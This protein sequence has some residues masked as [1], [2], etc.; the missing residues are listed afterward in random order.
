MTTY[1]KSV[2]AAGL[3]VFLLSGCSSGS[4]ATGLGLSIGGTWKGTLTGAKGFKGT[5]TLQLA[6]SAAGAEDPFAAATLTGVI[7]T[8]K[9]CIGSGS[10]AEGTLSGNDVIMAFA[11]KAELQMVGKAKTNYMSGS[12]VIAESEEVVEVTDEEGNI[13]TSTTSSGGCG[14]SGGSWT[15]SR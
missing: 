14:I 13:T 3:A 10:M 4:T 5:F 12:W 6:Q 11:T 1:I 7:N 8:D 2:I 15:A 9:P